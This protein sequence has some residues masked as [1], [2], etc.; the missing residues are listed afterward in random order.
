MYSYSSLA[1]LLDISPKTVRNHV[2]KGTLPRPVSTK[3]GPRFSQAQVDDILRQAI[4]PILSVPTVKRR[5]G[6]PSIAETQ[7]QRRKGGV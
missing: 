3:W 1:G 4:N 2:W 5:R 7:A 6:R